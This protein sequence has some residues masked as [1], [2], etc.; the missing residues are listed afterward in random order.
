MQCADRRIFKHCKKSAEIRDGIPS[1][2]RKRDVN[3][4]L[5]LAV[6]IV[7]LVLDMMV[8]MPGYF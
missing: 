3:K 4:A 2:R 7:V 5:N 8:V 1:H 6:T